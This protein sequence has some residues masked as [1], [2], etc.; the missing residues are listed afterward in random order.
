MERIAVQA[1]FFLL[2]GGSSAAADPGM[3]TRCCRVC[4][5]CRKAAE[6][7]TE[8]WKEAARLAQAGGVAA[9][10]WPA[11]RS[12]TG[13]RNRG[14]G[15]R[16]AGVGNGR[17]MVYGSACGGGRVGVFG[18]DG[19][20]AFTVLLKRIVCLAEG[21]S[22]QLQC[23]LRK[24]IRYRHICKLPCERR[25]AAVGTKLKPYFRNAY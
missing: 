23:D 15:W 10:A 18:I 21:C 1:F 14:S 5:S 22:V 13:L 17:S 16:A 4:E 6:A 20:E 11:K 25:A 24:W 7:V 19:L 12:G 3:S 9:T 8:E 2:A